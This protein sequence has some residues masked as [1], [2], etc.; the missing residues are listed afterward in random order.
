MR[1]PVQ[2]SIRNQFSIEDACRL[3]ADA[4]I[5]MGMIGFKEEPDTLRNLAE[6][7]AQSEAWG[8]PVIAEM[9][10]QSKEGQ[11]VTAK[12]VAFAMR[13]GIELGA[14]L[15]K[16]SYAT[17][18]EEFADA[19]KSCYKSVVVLGGEK[20]KN[21]EELLTS[22]AEALEAGANGVAIGRNVWQQSDPAGMC[23]ALVSLV[24]GNATVE[25]ALEEMKQ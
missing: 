2:G 19:L 3:G 11:P 9:L 24:H 10:V 8:M 13:I 12:D 23:R 22:V 20:A 14:D 15:I 18:K 16:T 7:S 6:L 21:H 17:P 25:K 5:C 1:S 4:V